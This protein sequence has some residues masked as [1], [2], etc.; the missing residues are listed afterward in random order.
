[1]ARLKDED[2]RFIRKEYRLDCTGRAITAPNVIALARRYDV[3]Q[4]TIRK[5]AKRKA[6]AWVRD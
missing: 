4:E 2:V 3:S 5:I 1:M 6:Y